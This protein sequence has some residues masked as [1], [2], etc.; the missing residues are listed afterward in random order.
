MRL[1]AL[2]AII[3]EVDREV[4]RLADDVLELAFQPVDLLLEVLRIGGRAE[5]D[6]FYQ[7][8]LE[9]IV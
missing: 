2:S 4:L 1:R 5:L 6:R 9:L 7:R 3:S 8:V